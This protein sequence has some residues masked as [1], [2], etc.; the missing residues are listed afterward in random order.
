M[1]LAEGIYS[2]DYGIALP[3]Q[4]DVETKPYHIAEVIYGMKRTN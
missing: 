1:E 2:L 3:N 4:P